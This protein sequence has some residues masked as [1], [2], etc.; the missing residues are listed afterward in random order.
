MVSVVVL[1]ITFYCCFYRVRNKIKFLT[2]VRLTRKL[3]GIVLLTLFWTNS[4]Q[5]HF[6]ASLLYKMKS[7]KTEAEILEV[8]QPYLHM[9]Q[10]SFVARAPPRIYG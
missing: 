2:T 8:W 7:E 9:Y 5:I 10:N 4:S 6:S 3:S 1:W